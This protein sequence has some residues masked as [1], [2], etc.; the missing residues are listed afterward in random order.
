MVAKTR[1]ETVE[2]DRVID[3]DGAVLSENRKV[4]SK[5]FSKV[6]SEKFA[7]IFIENAV[8][9]LGGT[10]VDESRLF[11]KMLGLM[12]DMNIAEFT[13]SSKQKF[14]F[15]TLYIN[16]K[17]DLDYSCKKT[18]NQASRRFS[19]LVSGLT[20]KGLICPIDSYSYKVSPKIVAY[21]FNGMKGVDERRKEFMTLV[22]TIDLST[23]KAKSKIQLTCEGES[24]NEAYNCDDGFEKVEVK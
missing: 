16:S 6:A 24:L 3:E 10:T 8:A 12:D 5:T 2:V 19:Q 17:K 1:V 7:F 11:A 18:K 20:M 14:V 9:Q 21:G 22:S 4:V 15:D 13:P 23:G